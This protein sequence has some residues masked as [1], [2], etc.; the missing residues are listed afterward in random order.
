M[1]RHD[2]LKHT[3]RKEAPLPTPVSPNG[4]GN[5]LE[6]GVDL[7]GI[8]IPETVAS[9]V[10]S[11]RRCSVRTERYGLHHLFD[12][13][14]I[15]GGDGRK[16]FNG[17]PL[18]EPNQRVKRVIPH[19]VAPREHHRQEPSAEVAGQRHRP[20]LKSDLDAE[21]RGLREHH[22]A[23]ASSVRRL[24]LPEK[25]P[26]SRPGAIRVDH[27]LVGRVQNPAHDSPFGELAASDEAKLEREVEKSHDVEESFVKG[28]TTY[29]SSAE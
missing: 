15:L 29:R 22:D 10:E 3:R 8:A 9:R 17:D 21:H 23:L 16:H 24:A 1:R 26:Q 4:G 7:E 18:T 14:E 11:T 27:D 20:T 5:L 2:A 12:T 6:G 19:R 13:G 28:T 25:L